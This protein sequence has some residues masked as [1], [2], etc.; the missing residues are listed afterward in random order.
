MEV[1]ENARLILSN[2]KQVDCL[3]KKDVENENFI[4]YGI[5]DNSII[6]LAQSYT[7]ITDDHR[8]SGVIRKNYPNNVLNVL[9]YTN[10]S[11]TT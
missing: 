10:Y 7:I 11:A 5:T 9:E 3:I 6:Y 1:F 4:K 2:M 8:M